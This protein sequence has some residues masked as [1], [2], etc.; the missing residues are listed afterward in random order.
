MLRQHD[1]SHGHGHTHGS[2][3]HKATRSRSR[4]G[5]NCCTT[6]RISKTRSF[7]STRRMLRERTI[8][9]SSIIYVMDYR[10]IRICDLQ[11]KA[12]VMQTRQRPNKAMHHRTARFTRGR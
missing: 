4:R 10:L 12:R 11:Q 1:H 2:R 6:C 7:T 8:I 5:I 9:E 3:C